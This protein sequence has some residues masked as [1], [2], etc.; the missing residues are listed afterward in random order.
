MRSSSDRA[1]TKS[2]L[3][4]TRVSPSAVR[5]A[6][7]V[8][9]LVTRANALRRA[10]ARSAFTAPATNNARDV[11]MDDRVKTAVGTPLLRRRLT[12]ELR[13]AREFR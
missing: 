5:R 8:V 9:A 13:A 7:T 2:N 4:F 3:A 10:P 11:P 6:A 1:F 12:L